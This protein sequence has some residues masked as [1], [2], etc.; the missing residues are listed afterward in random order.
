MMKGHFL[1]LV[2][3]LRNSL[4]PVPSKWQERGGLMRGLIMLQKAT[5][6]QWFFTTGHIFH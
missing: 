2:A 3:H 6:S 5:G 4:L 1:L